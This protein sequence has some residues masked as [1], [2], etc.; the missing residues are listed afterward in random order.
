MP[1]MMR[2]KNGSLN[3]RVAGS[4]MT[5]AIDSLRRVTRLRAARFG[6]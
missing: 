4:V 5:T 2:G 6:T 3:R 1:R